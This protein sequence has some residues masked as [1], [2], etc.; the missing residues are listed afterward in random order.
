M[1]RDQQETKKKAK[2][3]IVIC[4]CGMAGSGKSTVAKKLARKYGLKYYSG[5]DALKML[6]IERGHQPIE[7]GWWETEEGMR[8]LNEREKDPKF[9]EAVDKKLL[10]IASQGNVILDSWTMPWLLKEGFKIWL[11]AS[12]ERRAERIA[13]RDGISVEEAMEALKKKEEKTKA[14]Y[15]KLY[16]F[17]LGE[18]FE[19][20]HLILD[21]EN[22][23][24]RE[25]F[26]IL[27]EV[28]DKVV[29]GKRTS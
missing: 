19:P 21:T 22:L 3:P 14:I 15:K 2:K 23:S 6:A 26:Q 29:F 11:E 8:F 24:A 17:S 20:F 5:G 27:C 4:I 18:D 12:S 10:E 13:K 1:T 9:D 16:G 28:I 7:H 25:V